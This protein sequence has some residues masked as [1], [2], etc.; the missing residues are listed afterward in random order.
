MT[1]HHHAGHAADHALEGTGADVALSEQHAF[2]GRAIVGA[3]R[4]LEVGAGRGHLARRLQA[5]GFEVTALDLALPTRDESC[6]VRWVQGD[7]L[8]FEDAPVDAVLFTASLHHI[9]PLATALDRAR[10]LLT[11]GG[12]LVIDDFDLEAPDEGTARW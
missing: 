9:S 12:V 8:S 11:P 2:V 10:Q 3:R 1:R 7:F 5:D 4:V 6:G